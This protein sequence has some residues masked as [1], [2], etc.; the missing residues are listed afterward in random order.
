MD[1]YKF[2][3]LE[4]KLLDHSNLTPEV[5]SVVRRAIV[6]HADAIESIRNGDR[7]LPRD[8]LKGLPTRGSHEV[9]VGRRSATG[10]KPMS[11]QKLA[12]VIATPQTTHLC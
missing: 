8:S 4:K 12:G 3:E 11:T 7:S 6:A 10:S 1:I 5:R 9:E 2:L